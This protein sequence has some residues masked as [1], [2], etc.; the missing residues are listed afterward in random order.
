MA[1]PLR[2]THV[3]RTAALAHCSIPVP[4]PLPAAAIDRLVASSSG[5][6]LA[7]S[8]AGHAVLLMALLPHKGTTHL[9]WEFVGKFK[10]H[11]GA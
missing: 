2:A 10:A 7:A 11:E 3:R 6:L 1:G 8:D 4:T 9:K 5:Q